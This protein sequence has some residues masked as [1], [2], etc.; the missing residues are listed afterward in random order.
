[1]TLEGGRHSGASLLSAA[2]GVWL[3]LSVLLWER[4]QVELWYS[5]AIGAAMAV[6]GLVTWGW[7]SRLHWANAPLAV[8]LFL[9]T[10]LSGHFARGM[11]LNH[12]FVSLVV[13][14]LS[15]LPFEALTEPT[16]SWSIPPNAD[17]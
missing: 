16:E 7:R 13:L 4:T 9:A 12:L 5:C 14:V 10:V 15:F 17:V 2:M 6:V 1:M 8:A 11:V 3:M